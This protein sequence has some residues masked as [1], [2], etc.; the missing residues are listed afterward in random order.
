[1][2]KG[3]RLSGA[4]AWKLRNWI[5]GRR[6]EASRTP[7]GQLATK[8]AGELGF[9]VTESHVRQARI[10]CGVVLVE[11]LDRQGGVRED[12]AVLARAVGRLYEMAGRK[13]PEDVGRIARGRGEASGAES[14]TGPESTGAALPPLPDGALV[15][16]AEGEGQ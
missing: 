3:I 5:D 4:Q 13:W 7:A 14:S 11:A 6:D 8:A 2:G 9:A 15:P 12:V 16:A 1:M 10:D